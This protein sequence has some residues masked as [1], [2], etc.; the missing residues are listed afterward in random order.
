MTAS[1][2]ASSV[3]CTG[4]SARPTTCLCPVTVR[5]L[6]KEVAMAVSPLTR[7]NVGFYH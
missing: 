1:Q 3:L 6:N 4:L 2:A 7:G 5:R